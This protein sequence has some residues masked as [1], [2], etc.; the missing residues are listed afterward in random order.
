[1]NIQRLFVSQENSISGSLQS[2][3]GR[4]TPSI[5]INGKGFDS[6]AMQNIFMLFISSATIARKSASFV[7]S[8]YL[9]LR[10]ETDSFHEQRQLL[11]KHAWDLLLETS[12]FC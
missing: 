9:I 3:V 7:L 10:R 6:E 8:V 12:E 2:Q 1:M 4:I 5:R 11:L